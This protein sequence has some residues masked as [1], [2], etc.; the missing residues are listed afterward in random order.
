MTPV[1]APGLAN[2]CDRLVSLYRKSPQRY[3]DISRRV[4]EGLTAKR[5]QTTERSVS[6]DTKLADPQALKSTPISDLKSVS[7][8]A[9]T[10][11][12][13]LQAVHDCPKNGRGFVQAQTTG[14]RS[15]RC[16]GCGAIVTLEKP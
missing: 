6:E 10:L 5:G 4:T 11:Q 14:V 8:R 9:R 7:P 12:G 2:L 16:E 3:H 13:R 15:W 1:P